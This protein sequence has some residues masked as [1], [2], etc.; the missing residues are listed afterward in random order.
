M[1]MDK[2]KKIRLLLLV[3]MFFTTNSL[4]A[5]KSEQ[6]K[7]S[8][9]DELA[10]VN[11]PQ[12]G[13]WF[14]T[15]S[16]LK[17]NHYLV[18]LDS[19]IN[20]SKFDLVF[21]SARNGV[22]FFDTKKMLPIFKAI[23][24]KAHQHHIKIGLQ[25]FEDSKTPVAIDNT[26][27]YIT[28]LEF[29]LN[30][31]GVGE[32]AGESKHVRSEN[33]LIKSELLK[34][35]AF[36]K[37]GNGFFDKA[38]LTDVTDKCKWESPSK[39]KV[40]IK[41]D[42]GLSLKGYAVYVALQHFYNFST[43]FGND[44]SLRF[45]NV[46]AAYK[47][48]PLDGICLDEYANMRPISKGDL[49]KKKEVFRERLYSL[50]MAKK[51]KEHTGTDL[52]KTLFLMRYAP[53]GEASVRMKAINTY[54]DFM[55]KGPL[56]VEQNVYDSTKAMF[57]KKAFIAA[58]DTYHN[59]LTTDE[60]WSTGINW[61]NIPRE[62][63]QTDEHTPL[64]TQMGIAFN[65]PNNV[66]YNMYYHKDIN[67]LTEKALTDLRYGIRT[68][69]HAFNDIRWGISLEK[70]EALAAINPVENC[71]RLLNHFNPSLPEV[72]LLVIFGMEAI[73]NWYPNEAKRGLYDINDK[74]A[75]EEKAV[76]IWEAGYANALIPT[77]LIE[78]NRL[79]VLPD[80]KVKYNGHVFDAVAFLNPQYSKETTLKFLEELVNKKGKL[81]I[82]GSAT[83]DF[84]GN[85][86]TK[87]V[88]NLRSKVVADSF[89]EANMSKL[90][91]V[92]NKVFSGCKNT[93]GS[94]V[95]TDFNSLKTNQLT[96]FSFQSNGNTFS[97]T[98]TGMIAIQLDKSGANLEKLAANGFFE[99]K[100]NG[101]A[102]LTLEKPTDLFLSKSKKGISIQLV[103]KSH[104]IKVIQNRL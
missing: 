65:Y 28:E 102:I 43:N 95:F 96:N 50:P 7:L 5:Q 91:I 9:V 104:S 93:D 30:D 29:D 15:P 80:G 19:I 67:K 87:R 62:Y 35:Y 6:V 60:I 38:S 52:E 45:T 56:F 13:Y 92:K 98:Y 73:A 69:Y 84:M 11:H 10:N 34:A 85:D 59:K 25:F 17:E 103:D 32:G 97:G 72:K 94:L 23:V 55:R 47:T 22:N 71:A 42:G 18:Q 46:M 63:G 86:I 16:S 4:F 68:H 24:E 21:L 79:S 51:F 12:I 40:T 31:N 14:I 100:K 66:L 39:N 90:G 54:M 99:L 36:K 20:F 101:E 57:G 75:I 58:H 26:D 37:T 3:A 64:P 44:A 83:N 81:L 61:W 76:A 77:D 53:T 1:N 48:I 49:D 78:K 89:I 33:L 88:A 41:L 2:G 82:E 27:R 74:L 70:T 8:Y